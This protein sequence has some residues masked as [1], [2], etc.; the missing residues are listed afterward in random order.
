MIVNKKIVYGLMVCAIFLLPVF[1]AEA[2][3][4]YRSSTS[5]NLN[6]TA[7]SIVVNKPAGVIEG[8][9]LI[10]SIAVRPET[11]TVTPPS[12]WTL[13]VRQNNSIATVNA[14][15][16]YSKVAGAS[17]PS[18]YTWS[19]SVGSTG[20]VGSISAF[21]GVD[22]TDPIN[23]YGSFAD[24]IASYSIVAPSITTTVDGAMILTTHVT[25]SSNDWT[26]PSGM[27]EMTDASSLAIPNG[28]GIGIETNYL[29]QTS[30]GSTSSKTATFSSAGGVASDIGTGITIALNPFISDSVTFVSCGTASTVASGN[31]TAVNIPSGIQNNDILIT[32]VHQLDNVNT[33]MTG[34]TNNVSG[35]GN[36]SNRLEIFWK[37]TTGTE[38]AQ[39]VT[40]TGGSSSIAQI[41][42]FRGAVTSGDPFDVSGTVQSN[43]GSP[44]STA[45]I[46]T[47]IVNTLILHVFGSA[48][49]NTWG[50]YTG[51]ALIEI[52]NISN[53]QSTIYDN[54]LGIAYSL[55][56][57]TG[58]VG[59]AGATQTVNGPDAGV[60]VL[61][62]LKPQVN[63][64]SATINSLNHFYENGA[65]KVRIDYTLVDPQADSVNL[66]TNSNQVQYATSLGG[67]W[68]DAT[69]SGDT[70]GLSS[71]SGGV[72]HDASTE[73]LY[74]DAS[75]VPDGNYYIQI[76]P[77]DG[78]NYSSSYG[79]SVTTIQILNPKGVNIMRHG[80]TFLDGLKQLFY[81]NGF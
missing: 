43:A 23:T 73:P 29:L 2:S 44:I 10:A 33:S 16:I 62:A 56:N 34:W 72:V 1:K 7:S 58:S 36:T 27:T 19:F 26:P 25:S 77:N 15:L 53:N 49:D 24:T 39:T 38:S 21:T 37:R 8:D 20:S 18:T 59:V 71:S 67:S 74:W 66:T 80:R 50:S 46:T 76:K 40:H 57:P 32:F 30:A 51:S 45:S 63:S 28:V 75:G 61:L 64:P 52:A 42:A 31:L 68:S 54:S 81:F 60:S 65:N 35:N 9:V 78:T 55:N 48:D 6:D 13:V 12:G 69:L 70:S 4:A 14:V 79:Q 3:I 22:L 11:L 47:T 5:K 17:E 41:C